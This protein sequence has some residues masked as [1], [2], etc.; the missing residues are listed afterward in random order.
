MMEGSEIGSPVWVGETG[1]A[2]AVL[3][4]LPLPPL[5]VG[6]CDRMAQQ[7]SGAA[8]VQCCIAG[9]AVWL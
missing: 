8:V 4:A 2:A 5:Q 7:C 9:V 1:A 3:V 6:T